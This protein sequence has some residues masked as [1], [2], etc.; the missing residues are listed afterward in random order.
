MDYK[1]N[2]KFLD[3]QPYPLNLNLIRNMDNSVFF[4]GSKTVQCSFPLISPLLLI[5]KKCASYF[6]RAPAN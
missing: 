3:L 1:R 2:F 5:S 4:S 6:R